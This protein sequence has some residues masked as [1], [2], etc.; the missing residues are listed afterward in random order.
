MYRRT[1]IFY[2]IVDALF[3]NHNLVLITLLC[4]AIP[5]TLLL[6]MRS[7]GYTATAAIRIA[8]EGEGMRPLAGG[9][10]NTDQ[11]STWKTPAEINV[12][13]LSTLLVDVKEGGFVDDIFKRAALKNPISLAPG[14]NDKRVG[15]FLKS[16]SLKNE[17][18]KLFSISLTWDDPED[19]KKLV[20]AVQEQYLAE[21]VRAKQAAS[22]NSA[23]FL[24][25]QIDQ[26]EQKVRDASAALEHFRQKHPELG[27]DSH[28]QTTEYL[29]LL[30]ERLQRAQVIAAEGGEQ[31]A[32]LSPRLNQESKFIE[33]ESEP[34]PSMAGESP[35]LKRLQEL[36]EKRNQLISGDSPYRK[37][38]EPVRALDQQIEQA[39]Q[40][41]GKERRQ[42]QRTGTK[43]RQLNPL[44]SDLVSEV[45]RSRISAK[46]AKSEIVA[47]TQ[48]IA[49]QEKI[50]QQLPALQLEINQLD[51]RLNLEQDNLGALR[52][53]YSNAL[54][55]TNLEKEKA[56][57][58]LK[59]VG[60]VVA[61]SLSGTK[62]TV[63]MGLISLVL[64]AIVA[65]LMVAL[66]EWSDPTIRYETDIEQVLDIPVLTG[67]PE[68]SAVLTTKPVT[69]KPRKNRG[70]LSSQDR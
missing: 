7:T 2:R 47:L 32:T 55:Q 36:Q 50:L 63:T 11:T 67:L 70:L 44:Y 64:G 35:A 41:I 34:M 13:N 4:V 17:Q 57:Q 48:R 51:I 69:G 58:T 54:Q 52:K 16:I 30:Q 8:Q 40:E 43:R 27:P 59:P 45:N 53:G 22:E 37:D 61:V 33:S 31:A 24:K 6:T 19:C 23:A 21:H 56:S 25:T 28:A 26:Q 65:G 18:D 9:G 20:Q 62:K 12:A 39:R 15:E 3:R 10:I 1:S 49:K 38:S 14:A 5:V 46:T 42:L 68:T 60:A 66:R 29:Q